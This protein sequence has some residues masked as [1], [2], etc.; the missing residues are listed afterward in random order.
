MMRLTLATTNMG[1]VR[2]I[3]RVLAALP[4][5]VESVAAGDLPPVVE[6]GETFTENACKK[7][8]HYAQ[9]T[10]CLALADDSGLEVDALQGRP[11]VHSARY[12]G[13]AANDEMNNNKLLEALRDVPAEQRTARFRC[14]L[15]VAAPDGRCV[16]AE[17]ICAGT[18][19]F[20]PRGG[21]GFGYDPLFLLPDGRTMAE[22]S[23]TEKNVISHRGQAL[24]KL[25]ELLSEFKEGLA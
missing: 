6:D 11:G 10:G 14:V 13:D 24:K 15:A 21:Q 23:V 4:V 25:A 19:A 16:T 20:A 7:A 2:E 8:R 18:I 12:A 17:G 9:H 5:N 1:K 3:E 22:L